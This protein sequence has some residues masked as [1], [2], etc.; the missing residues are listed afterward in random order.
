LSE[1]LDE[2]GLRHDS[3]I[4][5]APTVRS[6]AAIPPTIVMSTGLRRLAV[7]AYPILS[8]DDRQWIESIRAR[9][10]PLAPRLAAHLTLVFPTEVA[11]APV[12]AQV[13]QSLRAAAS[14]AVVLRRAIAFRDP[15]GDG[16]YIFLLSEEGHQQLLALHDALYDG[17]LAGHR[18][19]D[20]PFVPHITV[21][22]HPQLDE[23]ERI[24]DQLNEERR[25]LRARINS[26]DVIEVHGSTARTIAKIP[27]EPGRS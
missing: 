15:I 17:I 23:C 19:R 8:D 25:T 1:Q 10:D 4:V 3:T 12:V 2:T 21:G 13:R 26:L 7:V 9:Y 6:K 22:A 24:A 5:R 11:P 20:I 27:L 14:M 18:R 16:H